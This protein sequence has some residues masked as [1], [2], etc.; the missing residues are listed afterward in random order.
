MDLMGDEAIRK[1]NL[2]RYQSNNWLKMHG[3]VMRRKPFK[4]KRVYIDEFPFSF[5]FP[6]V[7]PH[8]GRIVVTD[9]RGALKVL[10][11]SGYKIKVLNL[12]NEEA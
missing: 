11:E 12:E 3:K 8:G 9:P 4:R 7:L 2:F 1:N 6:F 10:E 5:M